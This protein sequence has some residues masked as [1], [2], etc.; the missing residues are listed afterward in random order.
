MKQL[1]AI[2]QFNLF[3]TVNQGENLIKVLVFVTP[4][5]NSVYE[6]HNP[7]PWNN[8]PH[9]GI[10]FSHF[11]KTK[12]G[13]D[14]ED[15]IEP[16]CNRGNG[17]KAANQL[18]LHPANFDGQRQSLFNKTKSQRNFFRKS[19]VKIF[20]TKCNFGNGHVLSTERFNASWFYARTRKKQCGTKHCEIKIANRKPKIARIARL[21]IRNENNFIE[22]AKN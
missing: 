18:F 10:E 19:K 5:V 13:Y 17:P 8:F 21:E 22:I 11:K 4:K 6:I 14:I 3:L 15:C 2:N 9:I 12:L 7:S 1:N 16:I 20:L